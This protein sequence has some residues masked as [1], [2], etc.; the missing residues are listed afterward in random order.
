MTENF[1]D[2][3]FCGCTTLSEMNR[4]RKSVGVGIFIKD[5]RLDHLGVLEVETGHL[6]SVPHQAETIYV[7]SS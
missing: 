3:D 7:N 1:L 2:V 4:K 6:A 5:Q